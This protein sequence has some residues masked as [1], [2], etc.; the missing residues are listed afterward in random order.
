M[1]AE[2]VDDIS[3]GQRFAVMEGHALTQLDMPGDAI[4]RLHR[5]RQGRLHH[6]VFIQLGQAAVKHKLAGIVGAVVTFG[7]V[8]RVGGRRIRHRRTQ[9]TALNGL[10]VCLC[11]PGKTDQ[12]TAHHRTRGED[13]HQAAA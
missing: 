10:I 13:F 4:A 12:A 9:F 1:T 7:R 6:Q 8:E 3:G 11:C 2:R 5:F